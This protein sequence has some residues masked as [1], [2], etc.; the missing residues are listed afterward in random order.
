M[1]LQAFLAPSRDVRE[2]R[3]RYMQLLGTPLS[4]IALGEIR[5]SLNHSIILGDDRF[6]RQ[7]ESMRKRKLGRVKPGRPPKQ[8]MREAL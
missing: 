7:V 3:E 2:G 1:I 8:Q 6:R 5:Q 4:D